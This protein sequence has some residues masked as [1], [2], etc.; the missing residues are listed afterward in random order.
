[1]TETKNVEPYEEY[2]E[3]AGIKAQQ[4]DIGEKEKDGKVEIA[5]KIEKNMMTISMKKM[6]IKME[7]KWREASLTTGTRS[8]MKARLATGPQ[9]GRI[10][11][12]ST[13]GY[14]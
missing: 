1:M 10:L 7:T 11:C 2:Y 3:V 13:D 5:K 12:R 14:D 6:I 4:M 9:Q 8:A